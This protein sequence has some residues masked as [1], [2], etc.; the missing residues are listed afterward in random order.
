ME[1]API[2]KE[3]FIY[4]RN[5]IHVI[6]GHQCRF[7]RMFLLQTDSVT[8]FTWALLTNKVGVEMENQQPGSLTLKI[9]VS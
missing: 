1:K 3:L 9:W 5:L 7:T 4:I 8:L 2:L 6:A